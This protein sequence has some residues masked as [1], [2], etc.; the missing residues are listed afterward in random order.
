MIKMI[1]LVEIGLIL[2]ML[3]WFIQLVFLFKNK[4]EI[5]PLFVI[6]Y[7]LGVLL[8]VYESWKTNGISASK[9]E[10]ITLIAAP[11]VLVK[12]LMKK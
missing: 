1:S 8:L 2:I 4:R 6:A 11:I 12:I 10:I 9:Y 3:A 7:M 5:H